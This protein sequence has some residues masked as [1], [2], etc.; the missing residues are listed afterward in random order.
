MPEDTQIEVKQGSY[1]A[2]VYT[3]GKTDWKHL[4]K[5]MQKLN[6]NL[7]LRFYDKEDCIGDRNLLDH[8]KSLSKTIYPQEKPLIFVFDRDNPQV[9]KEVSEEDKPFKHW[10]NNVYSFAIPLPSH[11]LHYEN[12]SIEFYY[13]DA[14]IKTQDTEGRRLYMSSEFHETSGR[15]RDDPSI[16]YGNRHKLK[17]I[18][19]QLK[20]KIIDSDVFDEHS[21][22]LALSKSDF[23]ENIYRDVPAFAN[24]DFSPFSEIF[25]V[26]KSILEAAESPPLQRRIRD[27]SYSLFARQR[28]HFQRQPTCRVHIC[29]KECGTRS[30]S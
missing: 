27:Y 14:E 15:H 3:E 29:W 12:V 23:A 4:Q 19:D 28:A 7:S 2:F 10:G 25:M 11:R 16:S 22:S 5:A 20:A 26:V 1:Q 24:F 17:G 6:L 21:R 30:A 9:V 13:S 18:T 8:C